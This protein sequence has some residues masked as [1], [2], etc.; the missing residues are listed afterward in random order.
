M[1][2][3]GIVW[4]V[5]EGIV[6]LHLTGVVLLNWY[7]LRHS[8]ERNINPGKIFL[9]LGTFHIGH[10]LH[11]LSDIP[12]AVIVGHGEVAP[13]LVTLEGEADSSN[14]ERGTVEVDVN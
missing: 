7:N 6:P 8:G 14:D 2:S 4:H 10:S 9:G 1:G 12:G 11:R 3:E 5:H 13:T